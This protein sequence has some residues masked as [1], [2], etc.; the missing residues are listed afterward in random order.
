MDAIRKEAEGYAAR[1]DVSEPETEQ[2][3]NERFS[4][5][6]TSDAFEEPF[7][8]WD[9]EK[10]DYHVSEDGTVPTFETVEETTQASVTV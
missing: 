9:N 7:A 4:V 2:E 5:T 10:E 1:Y 3:E 8:V 6:E